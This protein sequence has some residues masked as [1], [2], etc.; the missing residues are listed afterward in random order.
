MYSWRHVAQRTVRVYDAAMASTRRDDLAGRLEQYFS[1]GLLFGVICTMVMFFDH[2]LWLVVRCLWAAED[3]DISP[4]LPPPTLF[5]N[6][7]Q[8]AASYFD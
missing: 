8:E 1:H 5:S 4:D 6:T 3:I 2:L 7:E